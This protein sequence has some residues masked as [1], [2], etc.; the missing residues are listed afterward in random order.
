MFGVEQAPRPVSTAPGVP[1]KSAR[2][3]VAERAITRWCSGW[4]D[5]EHDA[6]AEQAEPMLVE[7]LLNATLR[8]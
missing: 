8:A 3:R 1:L 7:M 4:H 2:R 6:K 5:R